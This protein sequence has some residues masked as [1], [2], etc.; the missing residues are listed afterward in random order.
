MAAHL[1]PVSLDGRL[2]VCD[3]RRLPLLAATLW[4]AK[5]ATPARM[6]Q[7]ND[8]NEQLDEGEATFTALVN[9]PAAELLG[10]R[11]IRVLSSPDWLPPSCSVKT[12][13]M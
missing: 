7:N 4:T 5:T 12:E 10:D 8:D 2:E 11:A 6:P 3:T 1:H 9:P 13:G